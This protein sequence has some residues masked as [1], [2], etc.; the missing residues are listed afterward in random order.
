[1]TI[2]SYKGTVPKLGDRV[3]V[4]ETA[5]VIGDV[6]LGD[7]TSVW[8]MCSVRGDVNSIRIG[9][10]TNIQDN[11]VIHV[12]HRYSDLPEGRHCVVGDDVT[13]GHQCVVHACAIGNQC[14]IGM[15][16]IILDGAVLH[17]RVLLGAGSLVTEG[18]VLDGGHLWMGRPA[19]KVRPLTEQELAWFAYSAKHY[20]KLKDD[21]LKQV[22]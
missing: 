14:L 6:E 2:R 22:V 21:Y 12:T 5:V 17:D 15:G 4:D 8:P 1:M 9:A 19:K 16:S 10:R 13:V 20:V 11:S 3:F 18:K 7:D